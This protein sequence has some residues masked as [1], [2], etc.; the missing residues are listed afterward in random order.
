MRPLA[1]ERAVTLELLDGAADAFRGDAAVGTAAA[2]RE[3]LD[4]NGED[5]LHWPLDGRKTSVVML[6]AEGR[7]DAQIAGKLNLGH[8]GVRS[9]AV[10]GKRENTDSGVWPSRN[11]H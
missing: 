5:A 9:G 8:E 7:T 2:L 4:D 1:C 10:R 3:T 6:I 11:Q